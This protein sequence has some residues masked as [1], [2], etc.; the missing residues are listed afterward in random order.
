[1]TM[2]LELLPTQIE[3]HEGNK[4]HPKGTVKRGL[5]QRIQESE[6]EGEQ[7]EP[8]KENLPDQVTVQ[9]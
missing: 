8:W 9:K 2:L 1:M 5:G 3:M 7:K 4:N 6:K